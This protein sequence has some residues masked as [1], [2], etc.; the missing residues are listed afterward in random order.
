[1]VY[2]GADAVSVAVM[3]VVPLKF[4]PSMQKAGTLPL[5]PVNCKVMLAVPT[6]VQ[7]A[8]SRKC[9]GSLLVSV[10]VSLEGGA[11]AKLTLPPTIRLLPTMGALTL[12]AGAATVATICTGIL[13]GVK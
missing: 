1:M 4:C 13:A 7:S 8:V 11:A 6:F 5:P 9:V 12:I 2:P 3:A 10:I